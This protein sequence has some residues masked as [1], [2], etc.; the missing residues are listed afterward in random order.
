MM[1]TVTIKFE[2]T[3]LSSRTAAATQRH[4][5]SHQI[6]C[7]N[8]VVVDLSSVLSISHS[9]ADELF[10]VFAEVNGL[11]RVTECITFHGAGDH[12]LQSI[13]SAIHG[14]VKQTGQVISKTA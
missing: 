8:C 1:T 12:V 13:A 9:Y 7:G 2:G 11:D 5:I 3:D 10:G 14:R 6:S 4:N